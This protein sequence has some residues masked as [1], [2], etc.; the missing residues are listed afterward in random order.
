MF[1]F[2]EGSVEAASV[3]SSGWACKESLRDTEVKN[4]ENSMSKVRLRDETPGADSPP[5]AADV[6]S[7]R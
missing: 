6:K 2:K 3:C 4:S 5:V 7:Q 1:S